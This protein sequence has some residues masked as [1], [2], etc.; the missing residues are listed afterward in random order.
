MRLF[1][2]KTITVERLASASNKESYGSN[3][4]I[5]G[6]IYGLSADDVML[7]EVNLAKGA[8]L[9]C[10]TDAD[11]KQTDRITDEA[12][13]LYIVKAIKTAGAGLT[14]DFKRCIIEELNS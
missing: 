12:G 11:I 10:E 8:V 1:F 6:G 14:V 5:R 2:N 9:Y 13:Q 7:S 3:G 4:T